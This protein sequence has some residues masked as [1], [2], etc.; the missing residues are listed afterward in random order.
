MR[1]NER[2]KTGKNADILEG[3]QIGMNRRNN[4]IKMLTSAKGT[5]ILIYILS[6]LSIIECIEIYFSSNFFETSSL[7]AVQRNISVGI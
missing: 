2:K 6:D 4:M 7:S 3:P 5:S 1:V